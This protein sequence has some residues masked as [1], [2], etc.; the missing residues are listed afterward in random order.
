M[1][2]DSVSPDCVYAAFTLSRD[3]MGGT[4]TV[5]VQIDGTI[6]L[7]IVFAAIMVLC[8]CLMHVP[9]WHL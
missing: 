3:A 2:V 8:F 5:D 1:T 4:V 6:Y 9:D 7:S